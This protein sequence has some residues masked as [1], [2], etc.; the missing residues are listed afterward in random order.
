MFYG[1]FHMGCGP[2]PPR[3]RRK[4]RHMILLWDEHYGDMCPHL[5]S[6]SIWK[7]PVP[8]WNSFSMAIQKNIQNGHFA[9]GA[10]FV[11]T[12]VGKNTAFSVHQTL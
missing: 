4:M 11:P 8:S 10:G 6:S 9:M 2:P 5:L 1:V 7:V 12:M 3:A